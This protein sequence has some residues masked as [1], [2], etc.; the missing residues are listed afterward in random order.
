M[1]TRL[2]LIRHAH[3]ASNGEYGLLSGRTDAQLT[4]RGHDEIIRLRARLREHEPFAAIY[5]SPSRRAYETATALAAAGL[6]PVR[7]CQTLQEIDCG[8]LDGLPLAEVRNRYP[9]LWA[10][11]ARHDDDR[12]RWPGG[13]SYREFRCRCLRVVHAIALAHRGGR[14][15]L[16]THAG[17]ITQVLGA[18]HGAGAARWDLYRPANTALTE[19]EWR[20]GT[21]TVLAFDDRAHLDPDAR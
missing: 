19:I 3:A 2:T 8:E 14:I 4:E 15:A 6:G 21:A 1:V 11:N 16:V 5:S 13:E 9:A 18:L 7:V 17:V 20:H 10:A 12:F